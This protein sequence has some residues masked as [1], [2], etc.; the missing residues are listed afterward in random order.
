[1]MFAA[2]PG[3]ATAAGNVLKSLR[4]P[5]LDPLSGAP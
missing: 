2:K 1:M 3:A 4:P 5:L